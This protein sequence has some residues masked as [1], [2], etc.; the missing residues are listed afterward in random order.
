MEGFYTNWLARPKQGPAA[1][2][3][4]T[5]TIFRKHANPAYRD[6]NVWAPFVL[7]GA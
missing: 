3:D 7:I 2:L 1:A 4:A 5:K 6:P